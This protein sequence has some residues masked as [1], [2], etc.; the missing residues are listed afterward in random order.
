MERFIGFDLG[1]AES[2]VSYLK[3][4]GM[5]TPEVIPVR[6]AKS[7]ITAYARLNDQTLLIG[8]EA[9]YAPDASERKIRFKSRFLKDQ[10]IDHDIKSF[11]AGVLGE[12]YTTGNLVQGE[13]CCFYVGCPAGWNKNDRERYRRIFEKT[14]YPPT[15]IISESRAALVSACRSKHLQVGYDILSHPVLVVDIGSSTTDFAYISGGREVELRTGGEVFLGGGIMDEILLEES[16]AASRDERRIRDAFSKSEAWRSYC[17][18]AARR[19]KE[20]YFADEDYWQTHECTQTVQIVYDQPVR[21]TLRM[22]AQIADKLLNKKTKGLEGRSF[23]DVFIESLRDTRTS[24]TGDMPDLIFLTGGVSR[25]PAITDWCRDVYPEAVIITELNP[26]FS[27][28][29][30]LSW[31][32]SIDEEMWEF[33]AELQNLI[34]STTIERIV[35]EQIDGLYMAAVDALTGPILENCVVPIMDRWRSGRIEKLS[36]IDGELKKEIDA[37]LHTESAKNLL[38]DPVA[39]WLRKY[40]A[41]ELEQYTM[42][43]CLKHKIP[44]R[45]LSLNSYLSLSEIDIRL[46]AKTVFGVEQFTWLID[47]II[48]ILVGLLCGGSGVALIANGLPGIFAGAVLSLVVLFLGKN[49]MQSALLNMNIPLPM[50]RL[51]PKKY[52]ENHLESITDEVRANFYESLEKDKNE[53]ISERLVREISE[54][55]EEC[56][57]KMARVVEIPLVS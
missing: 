18:F 32:G 44:Y 20:K 43:I 16:V 5:K 17:E 22:N 53:E 4:E 49:R 25:L 23:R 50:R 13:D 9:C 45:A 10:A 2:A 37:Y 48:S 55:I 19:L 8:E 24:I 42:P 56:L 33:D 30:G 27:V 35:T 34:D 31:C 57:T 51:L 12:L 26:E 52:L 36:E 39:Q 40:I 7:F 47:T 11:A 54:Q 6:D 14:G 46:N 21:L 29:K 41:P 38:V 15:K 3:K 1:D 28:S